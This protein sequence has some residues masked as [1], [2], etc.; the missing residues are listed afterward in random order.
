MKIA[1]ALGGGGAKGNAHIG[2]LKVLD[3]EGFEIKGIAGT[4]AGGMVAALYA[5]GFMPDEIEQAMA[6][7][8]QS[9]LYGIGN[10][11]GPAIFG[12]DGVVQILSD[13]LGDR[14]FDDLLIPCAVTAVDIH[15]RQE[16]VLKEGRVVDALMA[17][18]AIPGVFPPKEWGESLL[19]DGGVLDPVPVAVARDLCPHLPIVAS[20]LSPAPE[21]WAYLPPP[22]Y[23]PPTPPV[24]ERITR[25]R[26]AQAFEIFLRSLDIGS[27]MLTELRLAVDKPD[28][29]IRPDVKH[30]GVLDRVNVSDV[31]KLGEVAAEKMLP[32]VHKVTRWQYRILKRIK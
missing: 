22:R 21:E 6:N 19:V 17:T 7:A 3:R 14:T 23:F 11:G 30:I 9:K 8:D 31:V 29:I 32:E 25:L 27:R 26:V 10:A 4:S 2:V 13:M 28:V 15:S 24:L 16:V 5:A 20:V 18:I 1:V 12:V